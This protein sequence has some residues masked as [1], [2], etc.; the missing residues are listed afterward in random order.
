MQN[1]AHLDSARIAAAYSLSGQ[2]SDLR[3]FRCGEVLPSVTLCRS[4]GREKDS[5]KGTPIFE[6]ASAV[7]D[8]I[9]LYHGWIIP[10]DPLSC[11]AYVSI[12]ARG[13]K[14]QGEPA[15]LPSTMTVAQISCSAAVVQSSALN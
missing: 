11:A 2:N 10:F 3:L 13:P 5:G 14:A 1:T 15:S 12:L 9:P 4:L 7:S 6:T 8:F